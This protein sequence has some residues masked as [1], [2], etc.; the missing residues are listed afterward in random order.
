MITLTSLAIPISGFKVEFKHFFTGI[1][2]IVAQAVYVSVSH[3]VLPV[4]IAATLFRAAF[5]TSTMDPPPI[6]RRYLILLSILFFG[7]NAIEDG[8]RCGKR[9]PN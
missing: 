2:I 7:I 6:P 5:Q 4:K 3:V 8:G 9:I 1:I